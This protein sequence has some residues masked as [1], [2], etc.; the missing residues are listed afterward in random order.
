MNLTTVFPPPF[1]VT[2]QAIGLFTC[3]ICSK[4]FLTVTQLL[5]HNTHFHGLGN[6]AR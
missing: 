6:G 2:F 5:D 4:D 1:I 3:S